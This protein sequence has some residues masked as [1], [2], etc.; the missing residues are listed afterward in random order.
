MRRPYPQCRSLLLREVMSLVDRGDPM[1][2]S[3]LMGQDLVGNDTVDPQRSQRADTGA[4][5]VVEAPWDEWGRT[6]LDFV[7]GFCACLHHLPV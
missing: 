7:R 3:R 6:F 4:P 2:F 5:Q 1:Q